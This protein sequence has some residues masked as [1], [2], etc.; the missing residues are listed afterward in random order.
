MKI[1]YKL[2][3]FSILFLN[4]YSFNNN[5]SNLN[6]LHNNKKIIIN[7]KHILPFLYFL[8]CPQFSFADNND[9]YVEQL[10]SEANRIIEIIEAQKKSLDY[11][12][13]LS[14]LPSSSI[15]Y[16]KDVFNTLNNILYSFKNLNSTSSLKNLQN[17]CSN[18]NYIK[19]YDINR[20]INTFNDSKYAILLGKFLKY[21]IT[22]FNSYNYFDDKLDTNIEGYEVDSIIYADYKTMIYNSIQFDDMYYPINNNDLHYIIYRWNFI[23]YNNS[24]LLESCYLL[25][26]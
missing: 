14:N 19:K 4:S 7:R 18:T 17:L 9:K 1:F 13:S 10:T 24:F 15:N 8:T 5:L 3:L 25:K 2:F 23:K 12:P 26:I 21:N 20:L 22:N 11:L 6:N 16:N